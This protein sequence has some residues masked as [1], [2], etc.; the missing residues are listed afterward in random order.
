MKT[1]TYIA[2]DRILTSAQD[3]EFLRKE[4]M[5]YI[6]SLGNTFWTD[7]NAHDPGIT[8]LEVL[9]YAITE[10]G[11]RTNF[12]INDLLAN[13]SGKIVNNSFFKAGNIFTNAPLTEIDYRKVL[14]DIEGV[15]N[16][17]FISNKKETDDYGFY[18]PNDNE[19]PV[20]INM[21]EDKLSLIDK[22]KNSTPLEQLPLRGLNK[23][24]IELEEDPTLGD[25]NSMLMDFEFLNNGNWV[26][27]RINPSIKSW[28]NIKTQWFKLMNTPSKIANKI[29]SVVGDS[30]HLT[31]FRASNPAQFLEFIIEPYD[32]SEITNVLNHFNTEINIC[33]IIKKFEEK[34]NKVQKTF[35]AIEIKLQQNRNLT[36]DYIS[37]E[38]IQ[39]IQ[40][41]VCVDI[42]I[43]SQSN[44]VEV[45]AQ[46]QMAINDVINPPI[47]FYTLAQLVEQGLHSEDIFLG[48]KLK[49]G[50]LKDEEIINSQLPTAIHT[51]D[52]IA[53]LMQVKGV[54][55]VNN[56]M[57]TAYDDLGNPIAGSTNKLW[58]L[59]LSGDVNPIFTSNKSKVL[60]FQ[61]NIPFLLSETNQMLV[62]QKIEIYKTK[63]RNYKLLN[64]SNEYDFPEGNYYQLDEYYS[65]QDELPPNYGVG[66]NKLSENVSDKRKAQVQQLKGYLHFYDQILAD[67]FSQLYNAKDILDTNTIEK[68]YF[69]KFIETNDLNGTDYYSKVLYDALYEDNLLLTTSTDVSLYE[70]KSL[71]Y[72]RRNRALDHLLARFS[73]S[74]NDYVFMMYQVNQ[75]ETGLGELT[76]QY[77][78]LIQDKQS[79]INQYPT[80]S[81]NRGIGMDYLNATIVN[82]ALK[83]QDFWDTNHRGGYEL[84]TA[85]LL[86]INDITLR[87][88]VT[89]T[90]PQTQWTISTLA[91]SF[92]F[93]IVSPGVNLAQKWEWLQDHILDTGAYSITKIGDIY[94][95]YL[96]QDTSKIAR[97]DV[98][99]TTYDEASEYFNTLIQALNAYFENF[100]CLEHILLRPLLNLGGL[101]TDLLTVCLNDDCKEE[102]NYDPYSCKATI[103]LPG[104][105]S[106][107]R[108]LTFRK[109]AE[110]IF[111][112]EAPA[113]VLLKICWV[114]RTDMLHFQEAYKKW[115][116][117][118]GAFR[119]KLRNNAVKLPDITTYYTN[120]RELIKRLNELNTI[121]PEGNL[122]DCQLSETSNPLV[123]GNSALGTL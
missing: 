72:E 30:V 100:Y 71:F 80:L 78:D 59:E 13:S 8:I 68:T 93:K 81:S 123:L 89:V 75:D 95:L 47:K 114:N 53:V 29:I 104:Y 115:L 54:V 15:S 62:D 55:S 108:N 56:M 97:I 120:H 11:Y 31:V 7:Y 38:T 40:I 22:D 64:T 65:I 35:S 106:R 36:D 69:P 51:S 44:V 74:F 46:I 27:V 4:G 3:Y 50:F 6:E 10:L 102:A 105:L 86:G 5:K 82:N 28:N 60:L 118:Y 21:L 90:T 79:F 41:G 12:D 107:F 9:S 17:W 94:Y 92:V 18:L 61:K 113:Q 85:K 14:I 119:I 117:F 26:Q 76:F 48:P 19:V 34:K 112:Q 39:S 116:G 1:E 37:I 52:I 2:K 33:E 67:F 42:E 43:E 121:Y 103:V 23:V 77:E 45:M 101:D 70:S 83:F 24:I 91:A 96:M 63:Q 87:D 84:R 110:K 49:H 20:Y 98:T 16:A 25:L 99:F 66:K 109:Y 111:R 57:L 88:I 122:Y 73:E 58:C 32:T